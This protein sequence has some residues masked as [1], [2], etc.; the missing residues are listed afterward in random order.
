MEAFGV[1]CVVVVGCAVVPDGVCVVLHGMKFWN[2]ETITDLEFLKNILVFV[3]SG[4]RR[5]KEIKGFV[6]LDWELSDVEEIQDSTNGSYD[7]H[8]RGTT[9]CSHVDNNPEENL[10]H[11][12]MLFAGHSGKVCYAFQE[13]A[14]IVVW[15]EPAAPGV[16][17]C[18]TK[19]IRDPRH[20]V[21][22]NP[23]VQLV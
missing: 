2:V 18:G 23:L 3:E 12:R 9:E 22:Y 19:S 7:S 11:I 5:Y 15:R 16:E 13:N 1:L 4:Q 14:N 17:F 21:F 20:N 6:T 8:S 10:A